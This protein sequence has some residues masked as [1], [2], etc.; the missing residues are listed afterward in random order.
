MEAAGY[1]IPAAA[2]L[3]AGVEDGK[4]YL[5]SGFTGLGLNV[6]RNT[7]A[8]VG[9]SD[10]VARVDGDGDIGAV[11]GQGLVDG[12]VHNLIHQVVQAGLRG[13][14]DIHARAFAHR[15]QSLQDLDL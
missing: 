3:A 12:V 4:Y 2:E 13:G 5:Q 6:N 15:L 9:D 7:P 8:I 1:L 10:G 14:A 11:A